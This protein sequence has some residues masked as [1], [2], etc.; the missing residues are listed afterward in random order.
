MGALAV[1]I[2]LAAPASAGYEKHA[3][4]YC[5]AKTVFG[6]K[7]W[8]RAAAIA[9]CDS[10]SRCK[11]I[12]DPQCDGRNAWAM[13]SKTTGPKSS[14]SCIYA[15]VA[16]PVVKKPSKFSLSRD[17]T[18]RAPLANVA[19]GKAACRTAAKALGLSCVTIPSNFDGRM[20]RG[21]FMCKSCSPQQKVHYNY[22]GTYVARSTSYPA[23]CMHSAHVGRAS[24]PP[25]SNESTAP[26]SWSGYSKVNKRYCSSTISSYRT[27]AQ[28]RRA[29]DLSAQCKSIDDVSCD[30]RGSWS[31]CESRDGM[32]SSSGTCL[33]QK[34]T[35]RTVPVTSTVRREKGN[36][37]FNGKDD[38]HDGQTDCA[39]GDCMRDA[40]VRQRCQW[41]RRKTGRGACPCATGGA[42][43]PCWRHTGACSPFQFSQKVADFSFDGQR[44]PL[45]SVHCVPHPIPCPSAIRA[46]VSPTCKDVDAKGVLIV[47]DGVTAIPAFK[48]MRC[49][50]LKT[51]LFGRCSQLK[52][53]GKSAFSGTSLRAVALPSLV[54]DIAVSSDMAFT[55]S[56]CQKFGKPCNKLC[57]GK[58]NQWGKCSPRWCSARRVFL[59]LDGRADRAP[60]IY[61]GFV[62][63]STNKGDDGGGH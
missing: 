16:S 44:C 3:H 9:G 13:C 8:S 2:A 21:C 35:R 22:N 36:R 46:I 30:G 40:R 47:K 55:G 51:L 53:I 31:T 45:Q 7:Y 17:G 57:G 6:H 43:K 1:L 38:D 39:D 28:A 62:C 18:C 26:V 27:A 25:P 11:A 52:T 5:S 63:N 10:N 15:K 58:N 56:V 4:T 41:L 37:C 59:P 60:G 61:R 48:F 42:S 12:Y 49:K 54:D 19:T 33:Y 14:R 29:C 32:R 50:P 24:P 23:I 34:H 20:P